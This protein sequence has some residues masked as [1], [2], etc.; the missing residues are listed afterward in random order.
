MLYSL[1]SQD[2]QPTP[3]SEKLCLI[4]ELKHV[5]EKLQKDRLRFPVK[6]SPATGG[7]VRILNK[8]L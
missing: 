3:A 1:A 5:W 8:P 4:P 2:R 6:R 7:G